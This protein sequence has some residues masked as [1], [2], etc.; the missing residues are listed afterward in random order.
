MRNKI[1]LILFLSFLVC[2]IYGEDYKSFITKLNLNLEEIQVTTEDRYIN[3]IWALTSK[4]EFNRN[5]KSIIL[6]HGLLDGGWT[7]LI[8]QEKSL[9][10]LLCD[11]GYKV[12]LPYIRGTQFSKSHLIYDTDLNSEY[13]DFSFDE[14]A[15][16]DLPEIIN[17]VKKRDGVEKIDYIGHSQG[18]LTFFLAYMNNPEFME[19]SINKFIAVGTVPNVNNANHFILELAEKSKILD[20]IPIK[21]FLT[22]PP[23]LGQVL[24]QFCEG[25]A[26]NLCHTF[27]RMCF[28]G[29]EDT[30]RVDYDRL[31]KNIF[32]YMPGGTSLQNV[33]H[34]IQLYKKKKLIKYDYG[35]IKNK[36]HY[37]TISPPEY[38]LT[39]MKNYKIKSIFSISNADPFCNPV[40]TLEFLK[41][42]EDPTIVEIMNLKDYNHIDYLWAES[43]YEELYQN[44]LKF[45]DQ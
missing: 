30:G 29:I 25:I 7:W 34:W 28:G 22:F 45:L 4:D 21:N 20:L 27:L 24:V 32:M 2:F 15:Q 17:L 40:D 26:K 35:I 36:I 19:K 6:Q 16:Y 23:E 43:A 10:K 41:N 39:K 3:T 33:K 11:E 38:D 14:I 5:G 37:G 31:G 12:Y 8:L 1:F 42:I 18:T 44:F 13:W 9:A